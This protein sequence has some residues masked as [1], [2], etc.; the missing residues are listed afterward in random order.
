MIL[1]KFTYQAVI[2]S[3]KVSQNFI[4]FES[5]ADRNLRAIFN[6]VNRWVPLKFGDGMRDSYDLMTVRRKF[7]N[8]Q[9]R[10]YTF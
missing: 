10:M 6:Q 3:F 8:T 7:V 2:F 4:S 9:I 1:I 5:A